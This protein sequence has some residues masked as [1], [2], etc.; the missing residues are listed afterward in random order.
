MQTKGHQRAEF[1]QAIR[2]KASE[3]ME[4]VINNDDE[5]VGYHRQSIYEIARLARAVLEK[6]DDVAS[7]K[8][9]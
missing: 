3:Y 1:E 7:G 9:E 4:A 6:E 8:D 2:D 5:G